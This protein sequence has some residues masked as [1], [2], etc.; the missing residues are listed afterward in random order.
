MS[1]ET[2]TDKQGIM[3]LILFIMGSTLVIGTGS[4]AKKDMWLAVFFGMIV[5]LPALFMYGRILYLFPEKDGYDILE[6]LYGKI[7]GKIL[8]IFFVWY[9]FHLGSL[10]LRNFGEFIRTVAFPE[11]PMIVPI[12]LF[13]LLCIVAIKD[14]I[15]LLGRWSELFFPAVLIIIII[16]QL[17][18]IPNWDYKNLLPIF[19]EG[20]V[21][22]AKGTFSAFSFPF[23]E[24]IVFAFTLYSFMHRKSPYKVFPTAL[25]IGGLIVLSIAIRNI[26]V[27]GNTTE[28]YYFP[29]YAAVSK[30]NIAYFIQR[31]EGSVALVF[32]V[33]GFVKMSICIMAASN[34]AAKILGLRNYRNIVTPIA[35]LMIEL[36]YFIYENIMEMRDWAFK[37]YPYYAFP[38]QVILPLFIWITAEIK[39]KK[40][41]I[42]Q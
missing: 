33:A 24:V 15:E 41:A 26:M 34:G 5:A 10:V 37:I 31:I 27:L 21:P 6:I 9:S 18:L 11:T 2:I 7:A 13:G 42:H 35:I 20:I 3:I 36:S 25:I 4:D 30:V 22:V 17:L 8:S 29:S 19:N 40:K 39:A 12:S 16:V 14:G 23:G 32:I 38:F 28:L 1:K